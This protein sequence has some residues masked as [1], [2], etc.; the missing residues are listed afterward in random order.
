MIVSRIPIFFAGL[1]N[2]ASKH[3]DSIGLHARRYVQIVANQ[4]YTVY[5]TLA[6]IRAFNKAILLAFVYAHWN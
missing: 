2:N 1:S 5:D 4:V 6:P 3:L